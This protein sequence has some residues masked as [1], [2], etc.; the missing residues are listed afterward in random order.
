MATNRPSWDA[1]FIGMA[2]SAASRSVDE[3]KKVGCLIVDP[4]RRIVSTGYNG[5]P[6]GF[7]DSAIDW[8]TDEKHPFIIHAEQNALVRADGAKL[9]G[10]TLYCT[11]SPCSECAKNIA[12]AGIRRVVFRHVYNDKKQPL[13]GREVLER[14]GI[15]VVQVT[16]GDDDTKG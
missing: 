10:S 12:A 4:D 8:F 5:T 1:Y 2:E 14:F 16:V 9:K 15:D 11:H 6:A 13:Q 7:D 3:K